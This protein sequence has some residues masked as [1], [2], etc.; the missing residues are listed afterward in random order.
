MT[1]Q[2][3]GAQQVR[4]IG[5]KWKGRKLHFSGNATLRPTLSRTRETLFNWLRPH[6]TGTCC[7][8]AFAGSGI[9]GFEAMSQ[10][11]AEVV[12]VEQNPRT[13][14]SLRQTAETLDTQANCRIEKGDV[15]SFLDRT[16]LSFDIVFLDPPFE[17]PDLLHQSLACLAKQARSCRFV[18][19]EAR[20]LRTLQ[21]AGEASDFSLVK[22]TKSGDTAAGLLIPNRDI[23]GSLGQG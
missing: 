23:A 7:L 6:I 18:Y 12:F 2:K 13:V 11:A 9:L 21:D 20:N 3:G 10:G 1:Q 16:E 8:D 5:G 4:I 14:S 15:L 17:H 22:Q 19:A